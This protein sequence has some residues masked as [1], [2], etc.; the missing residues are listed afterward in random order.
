MHD[1]FEQGIIDESKFE[2]LKSFN[3]DTFLCEMI[4]TFINQNNIY[5]VELEQEVKGEDFEAVR[6]VLHKMQG[7]ASTI[8]AKKVLIEILKLRAFA[9]SGDLKNLKKFK[10]GLHQSLKLTVQ[11]LSELK[12]V[13]N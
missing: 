3:D 6:K 8:G 10:D 12:L 4:D 1:F 5:L 7:S 2:T 9:K 11:A 13:S